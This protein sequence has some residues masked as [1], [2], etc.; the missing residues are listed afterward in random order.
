MNYPRIIKH[1]PTKS[2]VLS[3][4]SCVTILTSFYTYRILKEVLTMDMDID[5]SVQLDL[6]F[7]SIPQAVADIVKSYLY[8]PVVLRLSNWYGSL[9]IRSRESTWRSVDCSLTVPTFTR[10]LFLQVFYPE[11][12]ASVS[13][14]GTVASLSQFNPVICDLMTQRIY[15]GRIPTP[16]EPPRIR[17]YFQL[18]YH[19][20]VYLYRLKAWYLCK[21]NERECCINL[22]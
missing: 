16:E 17:S 10:A 1:L 11:K 8:N 2:K 18:D 7:Y 4:F 19:Q 22:K 14:A 3:F 15:Y 12:H 5:R 6:Q 9:L 21:C 13:T 20:C